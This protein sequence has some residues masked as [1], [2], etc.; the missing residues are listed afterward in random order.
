MFFINKHLNNLENLSIIVLSLNLKM[1]I[2]K[3]LIQKKNESFLTI[4]LALKMSQPILPKIKTTI[5]CITQLIK[6]LQLL[7]N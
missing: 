5:E 4:T 3:I 1:F 7:Q 2:L 6:S